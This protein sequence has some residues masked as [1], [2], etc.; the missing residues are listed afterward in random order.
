MTKAAVLA[1]RIPFPRNS[2]LVISLVENLLRFYRATTG[3]SVD[4][5]RAARKKT[6]IFTAGYRHLWIGGKPAEAMQGCKDA[7]KKRGKGGKPAEAMLSRVRVLD[8][9]FLASCSSG[10]SIQTSTVARRA[11]GRWRGRYRSSPSSPGPL[12]QA[13]T[14]MSYS[15]IPSTADEGGDS[16]LEYTPVKDIETICEEA[17]SFFWSHATLSQ[18]FRM[19]QLEGISRL[20]EENYDALAES[21][22]LDL[23]QS[24]MFAEVFELSHIRPRVKHAR[25]NLSDWMKTKRKP[26]NWP[27]NANVPVHSELTPQPRGVCLIVTPFNLP[28]QLSLNPMIDAIAAGNVVVLKMSEKCV[29]TTKLMTDLLTSGNYVD[30]RVVRVVNG[31]ADE[32]TELLRHRFDCISYTGGVKVAKIVAEAA[33]KHL[34]PVLLE[35]GGKNP[36]FVTS[37]GDIP[38]AAKRIAWG[39]VTE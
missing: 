31:A 1:R 11:V 28:V 32:A 16:N 29:H 23:G 13:A 9:A 5:R 15:S 10:F 27:V 8:L 14:R 30:P 19:T 36:A 4:D 18:E 6:S 3:V 39:K 35:L 12:L 21:I 22:R 26:T 24:P 17:R 20:V 7:R 2:M 38:S 34:T 25:Q 37:K 33:A